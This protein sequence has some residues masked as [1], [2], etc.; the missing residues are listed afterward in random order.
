MFGKHLHKTKY[1]TKGI[2]KFTRKDVILF[3]SGKK[4]SDWQD[5]SLETKIFAMKMHFQINASIEKV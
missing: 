2:R 5:K 1:F 3:S 4:V